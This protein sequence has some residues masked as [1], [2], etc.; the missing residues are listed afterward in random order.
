MAINGRHFQTFRHDGLAERLS[1]D[2]ELL[3]LPGKPVTAEAVAHLMLMRTNSGIADFETADLHADE[4]ARIADRY[5]LPVIA[6]QLTFYRAM[7]ATLNGDEAAVAE[8]YQQAAAQMDRL[9]MWQVGARLALS[10]WCCLRIMQDRIVDVATEL[11]ADT[12]A[13]PNFPDG[14]A[15]VLA[16]I[17][18]VAEARALVAEPAPIRRDIFWVL[19]TSIRGLLTIAL[20]DRERAQS[21][22]ETLLPYADRPAG[23]ETGLNTLWPVAQILGDLARYLGLAGARAHY[24]HALAI[25]ERA[26]ADLWREA[27]TRRLTGDGPR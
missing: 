15:L 20:D 27:A 5:G 4:A 9:G 19:L 2:A 18:R 24:E 10:G 22:Y 26:H 16:A 14:Q 11:D 23:A 12:V 17:G 3:A 6:S 21:V 7:R 1:L 8:L 25:A 13:D